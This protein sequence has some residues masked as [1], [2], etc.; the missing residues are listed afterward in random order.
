MRPS[1]RFTVAIHILTLLAHGAPGEPVT[2]EYV[3][4]SVSTNPVVIRRLLA[5]SCARLVRSQGG[6]GGGWLLLAAPRDIT[7]RD[8]F[9]AVE[10]RPALSLHASP[11]PT[12]A[13]H[14]RQKHPGRAG[15]PLPGGPAGAGAR[16]RPHHHRRPAPGG[17]GP[18]AVSQRRH[19]S[20]RPFFWLNPHPHQLREAAILQSHAAPEGAH[21]M[22]VVTGATGHLGRLVIEGLLKK[23]PARRF[24]CCRAEPR[25]GG[26]PGRPGRRGP[27]RRLLPPRDPGPGAGRGGA[28]AARLLQRA[29]QARRPPRRG[30]RGR[31]RL[32]CRAGGL[33]QP[34]A[35]RQQPDGR[36]WPRS[37]GR[38]RRRCGPPASLT[39]S[40]GTA[41][42]W[43]TTP[44]TS[45]R[46][47]STGPSS[48]ARGPGRIA[49]AAR[50]DYAAAAVAVLTIRPGREGVR[51]GRRPRVHHGRA[52][53]SRSR[54]RP[55]KPVAYADMSPE[56]YRAVLT[57]AGLPGPV[58]EVYVDADVWAAKGALDD[59]GAGPSPGSSAGPPPRSPP[60]WRPRSR[61]EPRRQVA[62]RV[63]CLNL[64]YPYMATGAGSHI[65]LPLA[66]HLGAGLERPRVRSHL[67][68][69][70]ARGSASCRA[71]LSPPGR[72]RMVKRCRLPRKGVLSWRP[73]TSR[74]RLQIA[75]LGGQ[76]PS[77]R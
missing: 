34:A 6:P 65:W 76:C 49:A 2:S 17:A 24:R 12:R 37:T 30:D 60:R 29:R 57:G 3:A 22:I 27:A 67:L 35:R 70:V 42:T 59:P 51:A 31:P 1:S 7:L 58:A 55:G 77:P 19:P 68:P 41:G 26:R 36:A 5:G 69:G 64:L 16:P 54:S 11:P 47:S 46:P 9:Q 63:G 25:E 20:R 15:R 72:G 28:A 40:S 21:A 33:H 18:G 8:V 61:G 56:Q 39:S 13:A 48:A 44:S 62:L 4:G 10:E 75:G 43:R 73:A 52:G 74:A 53:R 50:A 45:P 71:T 66:A 32:R 23:V 14:W 38:P